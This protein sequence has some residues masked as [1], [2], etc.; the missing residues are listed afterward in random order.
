MRGRD[1]HGGVTLFAVACLGTL[2]LVGAGLGVVAAMLVAHRSAQSA[3]DLAA[4]AGAASLAEGA[5]G[6]AAARLIASANGGRLEQC[7]VDGREVTVTV[8]VTGPRWLGQ[9]A[10]L[11]GRA[12]A[13]PG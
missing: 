3:A 13:G 7:A 12:R 9:T 5:D 4:L 10:D 1:E 8:R 11:R 6:C 2:L